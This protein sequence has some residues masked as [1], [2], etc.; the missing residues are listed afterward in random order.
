MHEFYAYILAKH[1]HGALYIG[2]TKIR[3]IEKMNPTW[4]DLYVE[5]CR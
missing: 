4:T 1:R 2:V 5:I 3:T